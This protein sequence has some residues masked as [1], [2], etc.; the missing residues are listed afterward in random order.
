VELGGTDQTFNN[1]VGREL[2]RARGQAP[3][4][5]LTLPLLVG[6]DGVEKMSKSLNNYVAIAERPQEQFGKLMSIPDTLVG[7]YARLCTDLR[8]DEVA[9]L[10]QAAAGGGPPANAAKRQMAGAVVA[11]YHGWDAAKKAEAHFDALFR[12][13]SLPA[14]VPTRPLPPGDPVHLPALLVELGFAPSTSAAR[15]L[16]DDGAVR[17]DGDRVSARDYDVARSRLAGRVLAA[18]KRRLARLAG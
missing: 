7:E 10:E 5:V 16:V 2:Q 4:A 15:R 13:R 17:I 3:Q 14:D 1:L 8:P 18:G 12:E 6:T 9:A 11:L